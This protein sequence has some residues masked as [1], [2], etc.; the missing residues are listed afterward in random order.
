L[1]FFDFPESGFSWSGSSLL[2]WVLDSGGYGGR[3]SGDLL[4]SEILFDKFK[5]FGFFG[6]LGVGFGARHFRKIIIKNAEEFIF[7]VNLSLKIIN[8]RLSVFFGRN[9]SHIFWS[10][11][12]GLT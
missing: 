6:L 7:K 3:L 4:G 10:K 1:E 5:T 11:R 12:H 2:N 9:K 8:W